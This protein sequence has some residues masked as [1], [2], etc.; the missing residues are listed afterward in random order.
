MTCTEGGLLVKLSNLGFE[1]YPTGLRT[2][3]M[4]F[5]RHKG[6]NTVDISIW[7]LKP[8]HLG[9]WTLRV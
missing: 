9:P 1:V 8:Y 3:I 7:G 6:P 2:Q 4:G 5:I